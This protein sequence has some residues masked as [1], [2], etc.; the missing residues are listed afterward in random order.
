[1]SSVKS[2]GDKKSIDQDAVD[3]K[4]IPPFTP[5][6]PEQWLARCQE[7]KKLHIV[8]YQRIWQSL[9]Y[10]LKFHEQG[11]VCEKDTNKLSWKTTSKLID[12]FNAE[13]IFSKIGS[14][15]PFGAKDEEFK[16]YQKLCFVRDNLDG[17]GV[18]DEIVMEYSVALGKLYQWIQ[19]ALELRI[20]DV[21]Q[22]RNH[23]SKE[24]ELRQEAID[25]EA[26]RQEK[27][28]ALLEEAITKFEEDN[29]NDLDN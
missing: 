11:V 12:P 6:I 9:I 1:M 17:M 4:D 10:L 18:T 8:K 21:V 29:K 14:Y 28:S 2:G 23:K 5:L 24:R 13:T 15:W 22:R 20:G 7:F 26:E 3:P 19:H 25:R 27:R 16:E